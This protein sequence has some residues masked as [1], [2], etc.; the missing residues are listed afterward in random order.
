MHTRELTTI[1]RTTNNNAHKTAT[2]IHT[3]EIT[4]HKTTN[5]IAHDGYN[6]THKRNNNNTHKT[7]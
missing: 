2:T 3:R 5:N 1:H 4:I 6:N 7:S